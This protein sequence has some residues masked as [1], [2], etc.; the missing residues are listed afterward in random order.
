MKI[1]L[2][3]CEACGWAGTVPA[4]VPIKVL[5]NGETARGTKDAAGNVVKF[6]AYACPQC[7]RTFTEDVEVG[8]KEEGR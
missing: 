6:E 4:M 8:D 2:W 7:G 5:K 1:D 3:V